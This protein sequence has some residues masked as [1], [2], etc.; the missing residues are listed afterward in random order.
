M[1]DFVL[2][3]VR[4][5]DIENFRMKILEMEAAKSKNEGEESFDEMLLRKAKRAID[6]EQSQE[7]NLDYNDM[8][9]RP[10]P[11]KVE[12]K[13]EVVESKSVDKSGEEMFSRFL[14]Q[15]KG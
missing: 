8:G 11:Q 3:K 13:E 4:Q 1:L 12:N 14:N 7:S 6:P 2:A 9:Y 5:H 10:T 15:I